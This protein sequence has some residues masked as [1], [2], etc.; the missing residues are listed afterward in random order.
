MVDNWFESPEGI[1]E[2]FESHNKFD[3]LK[4]ALLDDGIIYEYDFEG[5][6]ASWFIEHSKSSLDELFKDYEDYN[7]RN[8]ISIGHEVEGEGWMYCLYD[9]NIYSDDEAKKLIEKRFYKNS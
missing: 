4:S 1:K 3:E 7:S 2:M 6:A 8:Y 9:S 5:L